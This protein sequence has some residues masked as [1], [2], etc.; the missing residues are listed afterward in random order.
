MEKETMLGRIIPILTQ[1]PAQMLGTL[2]DLL[3]RL[4]GEKGEETCKNLRHLLRGEFEIKLPA[5]IRWLGT[6]RTSATTEK[7]VARDKFCRDSKE[8]E[9]YGIWGNFTDWFLAGDGKIEESIGE[10]ELRYGDLNK[11][12]WDSF[13]IKELGGGT[14]AETTLTELYD[15]LKK[16]ANGEEG[17]LLTNGYANIF[18]IQDSRSVLRAVY[19]DWSNGCWSVSASYVQNRHDLR[20]GSR[21]FSRNS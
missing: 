21:V 3:N 4:V 2:L 8:V 18:Y 1:V 10:Q 17:K 12:S 16:Q 19:V 13:I 14:K 7:F 11:D 6:T 9:F 5:L 15:L 20:A